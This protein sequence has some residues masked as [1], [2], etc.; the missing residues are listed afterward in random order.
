M[1]EKTKKRNCS[2]IL[3]SDRHAAAVQATRQAEIRWKRHG[4][5]L[6]D[7]MERRRFAQGGETLA[8]MWTVAYAIRVKMRD[9]HFLE[10]DV[11]VSI[12]RVGPGIGTAGLVVHVRLPFPPG[13]W[14]WDTSF[15]AKKK[16]PAS[17]YPTEGPTTGP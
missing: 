8:A 5:F 16:E 6:T 17:Y 15:P 11:Q 2:D 4:F 9:L 3:W 14:N 12:H 7:K 1:D 13:G 10:A